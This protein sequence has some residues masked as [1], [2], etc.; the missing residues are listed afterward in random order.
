MFF[1]RK[2]GDVFQPDRRVD[3][4][5]EAGRISPAAIMASRSS[6]YKTYH[7]VRKALPWAAAVALSVAAGK[8]VLSSARE[9]L[10]RSALKNGSPRGNGNGSVR[11]G[12]D[13]I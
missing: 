2:E 4:T 1:L 8:A 7:N 11:G 12:G 10:R 9:G 5:D 3:L 6:S 13:G